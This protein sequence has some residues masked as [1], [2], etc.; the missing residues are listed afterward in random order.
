MD[1]ELD[2]IKVSHRTRLARL[3]EAAVGL[4]VGWTY[5]EFYG[6]NAEPMETGHWFFTQAGALKGW[7]QAHADGGYWACVVLRN[8]RVESW[9]DAWRL[10]RY[11]QADYAEPQ[12]EV[13]TFPNFDLRMGKP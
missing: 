2:L 7:K 10:G 9:M 12:R 11:S 3:A 8:D 5:L 13:P 6:E 4:V 1:D